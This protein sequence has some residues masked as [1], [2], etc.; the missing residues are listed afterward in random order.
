MASCQRDSGSI[1]PGQRLCA[2]VAT[3]AVV[4]A[5]AVLAGASPANASA[6]AFVTVDGQRYEVKSTQYT[7]QNYQSLLTSQPWYGSQTRAE[8]FAN[9]LG[10]QLGYQNPYTIQQSTFQFSSSYGPVFIFQGSYPVPN[11]NQWGATV[12]GPNDPFPLQGQ[13]LSNFLVSYGTQYDAAITLSGG[14]ISYVGPLDKWEFMGIN[15]A[16][17]D[18]I[19]T[20]TPVPGP[21][22]ILGAGVAC[23]FARRIRK[24]LKG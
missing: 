20:A 8:A 17:G 3:G 1:V 15:S 14:S 16:S 12:F 13:D 19:A 4:A 18:F 6:S 7:L 2:A 10:S 5:G 9:A 23:G 21:L 22:P 11:S 24:R